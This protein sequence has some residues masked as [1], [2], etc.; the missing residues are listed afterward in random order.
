MW[1]LANKTPFAAERTWGRDLNGWHQWIV[2]V[3]AT[4]NIQDDGVLELADEQCEPL[5]AGEYFGEPGQ[6][7][8]KYEADLIPLKPTT[9]IILNGTAHAPAGKPSNEF[10]V[11][12]RVNNKQKA[13]RVLGERHWEKGVV[14]LKPSSTQPV[15]RVPIRYE[16]A[17]GGWDKSQSN[18]AKQKWDPYNPVGCGL[19]QN[20]SQLGMPLPQIEHLERTAKRA[21]PAGFGAIDSFWHPR[22]QYVGTY[23]KQWQEQ[24]HPLLPLD[25]QPQCLQCA[26]LD[27]QT[28]KP[29]RG[30]ETIELFNLTPSG[31]LCFQL[32]KI[33]LTF[34]T[35]IA[36]RVE[37]HRAQMSS[38]IIEP[39]TMQVKLIWNTELLCRNESDYLDRTIIRQKRYEQ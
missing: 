12:M 24:R 6:S 15:T 36:G 11:A 35:H 37:E 4:Y 33:Y 34:T 14:G 3:K 18:P 23:D 16:K 25:W 20:E 9:D 30:A 27:Q 39:D 22:S 10:V 1:A 13:L 38:V 21:G 29:L 26:P 2:A 32:P 5:F 19:V 17:Y 7:S 31:R 8:L 28:E